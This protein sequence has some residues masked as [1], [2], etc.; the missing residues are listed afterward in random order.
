MDIASLGIEVRTESVQRAGEDLDRLS[1][2]GAQAEQAARGVESSWSGVGQRVGAAAAPVSNTASAFR[3]G[4]EAIRQQQQEMARLTPQI[5][6]VVGSLGRLAEQQE[7]IRQNSAAPLV[8]P[9][10]IRQLGAQAERARSALTGADDGIR[11]TGVS[12]AQTAA[13]L[14]QLPAQFTDIVT[15]LQGGQSP[16]IVLLQQGGQIKDSFGGVGPALR[17]TAKYAAGLINPFTLAAAAVGVL[18][19]ALYQGSQESVAFNKAIITSG[20]FAGTS[21]SQLQAMAA[22]IDGVT[23]TRR[24]AAAALAEFTNAGVFTAD[25]LQS[26]TT[27]AVAWEDATGQAISETVAQFKRLQDEPAAASAKL[28]EQYNYLTAAI[29]EQITAL[30]AQGKESEAAQLATETYSQALIER[31]SQIEENLGYVEKA[32]K[33]IKDAAGEA[34]DSMLGVGRTETPMDRL[35]AIDR[36]RNGFDAQRAGGATLLGGYFA[37]LASIATD[38]YKNKTT[39]EKKRLSDIESALQAIQDEGEQAALEGVSKRQDAAAVKAISRI[40]AIR[41]S[42]LSN[43]QKRKLEL[44]KLKQ[45]LATIRLKNPDSAFLTDSSVASLEQAIADKYKDP[46]ERKTRQKAYQDD[47]ATKML[48]SLREEQSALEA[49]LS[50]NEKL[51]S[52]Q[53]KRAEFEAL[54]AQLKGKDVLTAEQKSLLASQDAIKAQLDRNVAIS[55][56]VRLRQESVK[57]QE[58]AAQIQASIDASAQGR[59]EQY[60]RQ[61]DAFGMGKRELERV[62][63]EASIFREFR[64]YQDQLNKATPKGMLGSAEYKAQVEEIKSGLNDALRANEDYYRRL[65][66]L[67]GDWQNGTKAALADYVDSSRDT[68]GQFYDSFSKSLTGLEDALVNFVM[69]GKLSFSDLAN[70]IIADLVRIEARKAIAFAIG[71]SESGGGSGFGGLLSLGFTAASAYFGGGLSASASGSLAAG[72][73]QSGY[74]MDL[75][76]FVAGARAGGG[77][78][79]AGSMYQV[80]ENN[81]PELLTQGGRSYLIPGDGGNV[82]PFKGQRGGNQTVNITFPGIT[83]AQEAKQATGYAAK[84]LGRAIRG[85]GRYM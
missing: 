12:A 25:Q 43:E 83:N 15:S 61:L 77:P 80:G 50:T 9:E 18:G 54:I 7:Q 73:S 30:E 17:E 40:E 67:R 28:N 34:W 37:G 59:S 64:R 23:G 62:Q 4:T 75:S 10:P 66:E 5:D 32:W 74:A 19:V 60:S 58:R 52:E 11:R 38:V 56:E 63:S 33:G 14:R 46:K 20:N 41:K 65:D 31:S 82:V 76:N 70:S 8:N 45:D 79:S 36:R 6:P 22:A 42:T 21:A 49:Q 71:G 26:L 51:T 57:F 69:T 16:L 55:E 68:A 48:M 84:N 3:A 35:D 39:D 27:A 1:Q 24:Q 2:A 13:A 85:T 78:V 53:K 81:R 44:D 29:Y 47:A 72:A